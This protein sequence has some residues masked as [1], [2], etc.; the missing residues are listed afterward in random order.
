MGGKFEGKVQFLKAKTVDVS[1][2]FG[3]VISHAHHPP[4][5][6]LNLSLS[7]KIYGHRRPTHEIREEK[8]MVCIIMA[9]VY[10]NCIMT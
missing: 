7:L 8:R 9:G 4:P 2:V 6:F 10:T 3:R 1:Q 5:K